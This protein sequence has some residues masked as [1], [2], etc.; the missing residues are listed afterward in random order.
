MILEL[1][2]LPFPCEESFHNSSLSQLPCR[3]HPYAQSRHAPLDCKDDS[4][5]TP[6]QILKLSKVNLDEIRSHNSELS[7]G[8]LNNPFE[9]SQAFDAALKNV[10]A[11]IPNRPPAESAADV[12]CSRVPPYKSH[13]SL[14]LDRCTI[15]PSSAVLA[16]MP[17]IHEH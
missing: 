17:A 3:Y 2:G 4:V 1:E 13:N 14:I 6:R 5:I 16:N 11:E 15:A 8:L 9:H 7:D 10:V 12:V